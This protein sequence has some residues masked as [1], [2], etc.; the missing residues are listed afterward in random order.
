MSR[1]DNAAEQIRQVVQT[2]YDT[3]KFGKGFD[4]LKPLF[5]EQVVFMPP[6]LSAH[7]R[8]RDVCLKSYEDACSSMTFHKLDASE[9]H[10]DI[11]GQTAMMA[12]RYDCVYEFQGKKHEDDGHEI[13]ML[14]QEQGQW[15][16][17]W[18]TL[19]PGSRQTETC[20]VEKA[21]A[22]TQAGDTRPQDIKATCLDLMA[23][24]LTCQLTSI[25]ANGFPHTTAM[26]N[27]RCVREYPSLVELHAEIPNDFMLYMSTANQS[28][29]M[30]RLVANP[31]VSVYYCDPDN[32]VG[33]ML[34]GTIE[35]VRDQDL[36]SRIWQKAWTMY[37]PSGPDGPE[38][39]IL[40][41]VP[42]IVK[43]WHKNGPFEIKIN[44]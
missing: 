7:V 8:G 4:R 1:Q 2:F 26:N 41:L 27:L 6:G 14:V 5:H 37:Y 34:G 39:G 22:A 29:K 44:V 28:N 9:D 18:R 40:K 12:Y 35:V 38:Y 10:I 13:L 15:K 21:Q 19:I 16:L 3:C 43:G 25:D 42:T 24:S 30:A 20:P 23:Q 31:K 11:F 33:L 32:I 17:A 36:K